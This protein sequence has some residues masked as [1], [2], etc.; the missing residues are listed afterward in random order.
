MDETTIIDSNHHHQRQ[1][2]QHDQRQHHSHNHHNDCDR[3]GERMRGK[4]DPILNTTESPHA[5]SP[6]EISESLVTHNNQKD[7][8]LKMKESSVFE[9]ETTYD[10]ASSS[11]FSSPSSV[12]S[13]TY[14]IEEEDEEGAES[15]DNGTAH[16][17]KNSDE[18]ISNNTSNSVYPI[19]ES[20][21]KFELNLHPGQNSNPIKRNG[22]EKEEED[23]D[24]SSEEVLE[25]DIRHRLKY[26]KIKR[27]QPNLQNHQQGGQI[28]P[29][30]T[31][32]S[33]T[34]NISGNGTTSENTTNSIDSLSP[35]PTSEVQD[36]SKHNQDALNSISIPNDIHI[37]NNRLMNISWRKKMTR[38]RTS[39]TKNK[40]NYNENILQRQNELNSIKNLSSNSPPTKKSGSFSQN[41]TTSANI[42]PPPKQIVTET[43]KKL[44]SPFT[45]EKSV[46]NLDSD[47]ASESDSEIVLKNKFNIVSP[48]T[49]IDILNK[50]ENDRLI[51]GNESLSG[52]S[53][54][55][56]SISSSA[57]NDFITN[58]L[59][60][61]SPIIMTVPPP[62]TTTPISVSVNNSISDVILNNA[63]SSQTLDSAIMVKIKQQ[64]EEQEEKGEQEDEEL[65]KSIADIKKEILKYPINEINKLNEY[66]IKSNKNLIKS[67]KK[68][69]QLEDEWKKNSSK[70]NNILM[71]YRSFYKILNLKQK[72]LK[73]KNKDDKKDKIKAKN[74]DRKFKSKNKK[75]AKSSIVKGG[76]DVSVKEESKVEGENVAE[77]SDMK[78]ETSTSTSTSSV[79]PT[80]QIQEQCV[81]GTTPAAVTAEM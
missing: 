1:H 69:K 21:Q 75:V 72:E 4:R 78:K 81:T 2:H 62:S 42:T 67:N 16:M 25:D 46:I 56:S 57:V 48:P 60:L 66:N 41:N 70:I 32:T 9:R 10:P 36:N 26:R 5:Q 15:E 63:E 52:S 71:N 40:L 24:T 61:F 13:Q 12:E 18:S 53:S 23:N 8:D 80:A 44:K 33:L 74:K 31:S 14:S 7:Q 30:T 79:T 39:R 34:N 49:K 17:D 45:N 20:H 38:S 73:I 35:I 59:G 3:N 55:L 6:F 28:L 54:P 58:K 50:I 27:Y 43:N 37:K 19:T 29:S 65:E 68:L 22:E 64:K 76:I 51:M 77:S 47:S 11:S